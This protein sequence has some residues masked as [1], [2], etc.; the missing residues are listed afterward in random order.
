M[1]GQCAADRG[2][3]PFC[4]PWL[5]RGWLRGRQRRAPSSSQENWLKSGRPR[6]PAGLGKQLATTSATLEA[7]TINDRQGCL[8]TLRT[9]RQRISNARAA[10]KAGKAEGKNAAAH[11]DSASE[12]L[13]DALGES[14]APA[15]P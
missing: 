6:P 4:S 7:Y 10:L 2:R 1:E 9:V 14:C 3:W 15:T 13:D 11:L 12:S 5:C 8:E